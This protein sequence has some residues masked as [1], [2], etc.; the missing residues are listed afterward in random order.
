MGFS[1]WQAIPDIRV[2]RHL[3]F[4]DRIDNLTDPHRLHGDE[5]NRVFARGVRESL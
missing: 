3:Q 2:R 1:S 4:A 5:R